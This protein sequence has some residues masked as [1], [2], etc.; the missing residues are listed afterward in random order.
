MKSVKELPYF[1]K[2]F[3]LQK[4]NLITVKIDNLRDKRIIFSGTE[5]GLKKTITLMKTKLL[6]YEVLKMCFVSIAKMNRIYSSPNTKK[7]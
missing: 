5:L 1:K 3:E 7:V 2:I 4:T 6:T